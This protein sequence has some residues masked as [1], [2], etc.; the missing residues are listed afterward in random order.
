MIRVYNT[1]SRQ[2]VEFITGE[3]GQANIY[4]CGPTTY[5]F[6]HL[7][8]ARPLVFFDT[9]RRYLKYRGFKV[10][11]IQNFT[12]VDD[13]IINRAGE[14]GIEA[15]ELADRYIKE[16]FKDADALNVMRADLHPRVSEHI[17]EIIEMVATLVEKG[18]AYC[19]EG[20]VFFSVNSFPGYGKLSGRDLE[21]IMAGARVEVDA[22]KEQPFDFALWKQAKPGEPSWDSPWGKGRPGWHIECSAMS[23]KYLGAGFDIHGGGADLIFPHHEN[24]IAQSEAYS[25][26]TFVRYW[27]HNGFI[28][29]NKEKMSKSLGNFF[30]VRDILAKY[31][32]DVVRFYLLAT[33]YRNPLDFDDTKLFEAQKAVERL[34]NSRVMLREAL[35]NAV[36]GHASDVE[37][38]LENE[39]GRLKSE[40]DE[41]MDDDFNTAL[42]L[43]AVFGMARSINK[44]LAMPGMKDQ[45]TLEGVANR[46]DELLGVIG[47]RLA[48]ASASEPYVEEGHNL[49]GEIILSLVEFRKQARVD[50][51]FQTGDIIRDLLMQLG[52]ALEDSKEGSRIRFLAEPELDPIMD[53]IVELRGR[54]RAEKNF[55]RADM[56]RDMLGGLG[57]TIIDNRDGAKWRY[58]N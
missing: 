26:E 53:A 1:P 9:V 39:I 13:K 47:L 3:P 31:P 5:N 36:S 25:G 19:R 10:I 21:D 12:D 2:K 43:S 35:S 45:K 11:Y 40:F 23:M 29:V 17:P 49:V 7:G 56:L 55:A 48:D 20:D 51:D 46:Y 44:Y 30:I 18:H 42:A 24:E 38:E 50:R 52:V 4:V 32:A 14:E 37:A 16:Y 54:L 8:N 34:A 58:S 28:T 41:A 33:H 6:I 15:R 27:L 57:V 22:R